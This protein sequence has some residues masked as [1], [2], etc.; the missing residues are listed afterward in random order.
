[1]DSSSSAQGSYNRRVDE[2]MKAEG[3][4]IWEASAR[5][6]RQVIASIFERP[7][8]YA[9]TMLPVLYR[10]I[11]IDE[12]ALIGI[13]ALLWATFGAWRR[14][15]S[16]RLLLLSAGLYNELFHALISLNIPRY[17]I[18]AMPSVAIAVAIASAALLRRFSRRASEIGLTLPSAASIGQPAAIG[19]FAGAAPPA[20]G[21]DQKAS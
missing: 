9:A 3:L 15:E 13:P 8:A 19:A 20:V 10:G 17:Q 5:I 14:R 16:L 11:W 7:L 1:M 18:T 2:L 6:D 4:G 12:F 21:Q